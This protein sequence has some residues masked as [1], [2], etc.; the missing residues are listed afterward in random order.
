MADRR[1]GP[2]P[3]VVVSIIVLTFVC[4]TIINLTPTSVFGLGLADGSDL[5]NLLFMVCGVFVGGFGGILQSASR[6]L[7]AR[8]CSE[9]S[10]TEYFGL[11]GLS[12]RATAF[13]AP[14]LILLVTNLTESA[15]L[16]ISPVIGLFLQGSGFVTLGQPQRGEI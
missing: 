9:T 4:F 2:K 11:Y 10:A 5:P 6:S 16:G 14:A 3:V 1:L 15:R 7:M 12:G 8:H 13:L